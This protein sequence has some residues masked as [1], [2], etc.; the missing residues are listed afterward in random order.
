MTEKYYL[1]T[2]LLLIT[3]AQFY[4]IFNYTKQKRFGKAT[5]GILF[6]L[7]IASLL[8]YEYNSGLNLSGLIVTCSI[9]TIIGHSL[10]GNYLGYYHKSKTYDRGLHFFGSFSFSL[11]VFLI[12]N[13]AV[14][15]FYSNR[16]YVSLFVITLGISIGALFEILEFIHDSVSKKAAC[17][18][19]LA[20]TNFDMIFN[21]LG[22]LIAGVVAPLFL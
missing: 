8:L 1:I 4:I 12:L 3:V 17:Q 7:V 21:M 13:N 11:L 20:D 9:L 16:F 15:P 5:Q 2:N 18:H 6:W 19:G 14:I 10:V 22:A